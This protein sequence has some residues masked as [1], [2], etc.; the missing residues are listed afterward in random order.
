MVYPPTELILNPDGSIFHLRLLP[1]EIADTIILVGDPSRVGIV[2]DFFESIEIKKSNR[3]FVS[4]TGYY[5][6]RRMTA[7]STGIGT[8]NI[9]IVLNELD[10]IVNIDLE[11]RELKDERTR[12]TLVRIGTTGGIQKDI[13]INSVILSRYAAGFDPVMNFYAG[14]NE[15]ANLEMEKAF[16]KHMDWPDLLPHPCF[17]PS[18]DRLFKLFNREIY[19]GITITAPGFYGPQGRKIRLAPLDPHL[20][21]KLESFR[22]QGLRIMNYEME[23]SALFGLSAL[24]GHEAI[25]ICAMIANRASLEFTRDYKPV[26]SKL[27]KFTL[28]GL[29]QI[30]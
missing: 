20:N 29:S 18:S 23:S 22:Y 10:A 28:E 19:S 8:D 5:K 25:S 6:G 15:V 1:G 3:E 21:E 11:K 14:R 30:H 27:I 24:L 13:P 16:M 12:L 4:H 26:I 9:D 2:S 17:V 7:L